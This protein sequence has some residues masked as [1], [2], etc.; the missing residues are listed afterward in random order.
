MTT[1]RYLFPQVTDAHANRSAYFILQ[2]DI[3]RICECFARQGVP[4]EA[5]A[6]LDDLWRRYGEP[7]CPE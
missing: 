2:R 1:E 7:A 5:D 3:Q 4:S 6:I